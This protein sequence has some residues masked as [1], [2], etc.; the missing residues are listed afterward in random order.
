MIETLELNV[1]THY[2]GTAKIQYISIKKRI[3]TRIS[4]PD[5]K[6]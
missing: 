4:V 6:A 1:K 3:L 5:Q 2:F